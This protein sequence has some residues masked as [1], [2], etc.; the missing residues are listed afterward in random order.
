MTPSL[1]LSCAIFL[2]ACGP[3]APARAQDELRRLRDELVKARLENLDLKLR[4]ARQAAKPDEELKILEEALGADLA[5]VQSA[6]VRELSALPEDRRK[7]AVPR[8]LERYRTGSDSLRAQ[9]LAFLGRVPGPESEN[10]VLGAARDSAPAV[11]RAAASAFK[12]A[13][14][15][16]ALAALSRLVRDSDREVRLAALDALGAAPREA[17]VTPLLD[18]LAGERDETVQEKIVET[19]GTSG[20]AAASAPLLA[21]LAATPHKAVRWACINALGKIGD[22]AAAPALRPFLEAAHPPDVREV[23]AVALGKLKDADALPRLAQ[24]LAADREEKLRQAAAASIAL[25]AKADA[26][27]TLLLPA[28]LDEAQSP[29]VRASLWASL[30]SAAGDAPDPN[31]RLASALLARGRRADA[32]RLCT[33]RLHPLKPE[34]EARTRAARLEAGIADAALE[35]KDPKAALPHCR[36]LVLLTPEHPEVHRR[37]VA[38]QRE[39]KDLDGAARAL[40]EGEARIGAEPLVE[41]A[42][43]ILGMN[44]PPHP[45]ERRK[46]LEQLLKSGA[47]RL[48]A[49][50]ADK[51]EALRKA[52]AEAVRRQ[53]RR[54]LAALADE[55]ESGAAPPPGV[56]EA[57]LLITSLPNEASTAE[58]LKARAAAWR[59]WLKKQP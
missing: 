3:A 15:E 45:E 31:E 10:A 21:L 50:L 59:D 17:S 42:H 52:A 16:K 11:R 33:E 23:S 30:L 51:D 26:I 28:Y 4:L 46:L 58:G 18:A 5:E 36:Q 49:A 6:A 24:I 54:I 13:P 1:T 48:A 40:K 27:E 37:L 8:V 7:A 53:G 56:L 47:L 22:A 29:D 19:L 43:A 44:P 41:E 35:A 34:G 57:G 14:G 2:L 55:I 38:C 32:E 12:S 9:A 39:L 20:A 25:I